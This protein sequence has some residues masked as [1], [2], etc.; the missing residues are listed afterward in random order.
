MQFCGYGATS[1]Q[2]NVRRT[3]VANHG[4]S[5]CLLESL[6]EF[7]VGALT[8]NP[9]RFGH[10]SFGTS[11][12]QPQVVLT[13]S[14]RWGFVVLLSIVSLRGSTRGGMDSVSQQHI[15]LES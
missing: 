6:H 5:S 1:L 3:M 9:A 14:N 12:D 11:G 13:S 2:G 15:L 4:R 7:G 8:Y 10:F